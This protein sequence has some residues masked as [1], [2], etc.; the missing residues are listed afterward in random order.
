MLNLY[1]CY[2]PIYN[3]YRNTLNLWIEEIIHKSFLFAYIIFRLYQRVISMCI[4]LQLRENLYLFIFIFSICAFLVVSTELCLISFFLHQK[5]NN[6][7]IMFMR[8]NHT[9]CLVTN[10]FVFSFCSLTNNEIMTY[11]LKVTQLSHRSFFQCQYSF[12]Y[13]FFITSLEMLVRNNVSYAI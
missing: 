9:W 4:W 10:L 5:K 11:C 8:K 1:K 6:V 3:A 2:C 13:N 12:L 7:T